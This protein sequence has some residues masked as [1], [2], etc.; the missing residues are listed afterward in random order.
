MKK[1]C[2]LLSVMLMA[3]ALAACSN[4]PKSTVKLMKKKAC[5]RDIEGFFSYVDKEK[6]TEGMQS[7]AQEKAGSMR[8]FTEREKAGK[9]LAQALMKEMTNLVWAAYEV[10]IKRGKQSSFCQMDIVSEVESATGGTV[11]VEMP[12]GLRQKWQFDKAGDA[13]TLVSIED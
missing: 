3:M 8:A 11:T 1:V 6:V 7:R 10:D 9:E 13:Y 2:I 4:S 5:A 12:T